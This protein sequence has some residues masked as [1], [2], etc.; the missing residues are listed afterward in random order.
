LLVEQ[1][2]WPRCLR[3]GCVIAGLL[4]LRVRIP[5]GTWTPVAF[6]CSLLSGRG[7]CIRLITRPEKSYRVWCV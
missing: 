3:R 7:L 4:G 5:P 2:L 1:Y 6:E